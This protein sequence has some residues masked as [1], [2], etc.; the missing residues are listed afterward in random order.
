MYFNE[1]NIINYKTE[2]SNI[3]LSEL[4]DIQED[5][6]DYKE[7]LYFKEEQIGFNV[8]IDNKYFIS[9]TKLGIYDKNLELNKLNSN[10]SIN[11]KLNFYT[12]SIDTLDINSRLID[13][14]K[15]P[16][17]IQKLNYYIN[18][19]II[20]IDD[21]VFL[22]IITECKEIADI[23]EVEIAK[24][25]NIYFSF[26]NEMNADFGIVNFKKTILLAL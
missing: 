24:C 13:T 8:L 23:P 4:I 3:K 9:V 1:K 18:D 25:G 6:I 15:Y 22:E 11:K 5:R 26:D 21:N 17:N 10:P 16:Y 20:S 2:S 12:S 14:K 19:S 7:T